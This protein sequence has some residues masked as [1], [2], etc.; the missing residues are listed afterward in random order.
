LLTALTVLV[1]SFVSYA[2]VD[3]ADADAVVYSTAKDVDTTGDIVMQ[4]M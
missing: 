4:E 1:V 2:F 3:D